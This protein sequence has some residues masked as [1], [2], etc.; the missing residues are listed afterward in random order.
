M[1]VMILVSY[2]FF[3]GKSV[4]ISPLS[5]VRY[6]ALQEYKTKTNKSTSISQL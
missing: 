1:P 3:G 6:T 4:V 5:D 2:L